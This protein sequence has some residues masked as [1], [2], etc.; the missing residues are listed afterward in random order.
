MVALRSFLFATL[1]SI[2]AVSGGAINFSRSA[3]TVATVEADIAKITVQ[4]G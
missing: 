4:V 3:T 1:T 2:A